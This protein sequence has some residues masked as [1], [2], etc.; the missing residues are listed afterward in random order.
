MSE[1]DNY[2][3]L[4]VE[5]KLNQVFKKLLNLERKQAE[6]LVH[7][8]SLEKL[9]TYQTPAVDTPSAPIPTEAP[10]KPKPT[11]E[12][13]IED[14][15]DVGPSPKDDLMDAGIDFGL[16]EYLAGGLRIEPVKFLGDLWGDTNQKL[17]AFNYKWVSQGKESH[18]KF[19]P[20]DRKKTEAVETR[21]EGGA[22]VPV[23][24]VGKYVIVEGNLVD[25]PTQRDID[26]IHGPSTVT[27]FRVELDDGQTV[28]VGLWEEKAIKAM[29]LVKGDRIHLTSMKVKEPY[30]GMTQLQSA[31]YTKVTKL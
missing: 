21:S 28:K 15:V 18:W 2:E 30:D 26:T 11:P 5:G 31:K 10:P 24:E 19:Q 20:T 25:D 17:K 6:T 1:Y 12:P 16:V 29:D 22:V 3:K 27:N 23:F 9:F 7:L 14:H 13:K 8:E 4:G